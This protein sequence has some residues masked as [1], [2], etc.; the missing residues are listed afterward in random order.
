MRSLVQKDLSFTGFL[1]QELL[2][3]DTHQN[4][5]ELILLGYIV[6]VSMENP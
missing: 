5:M 1:K 4:N 3:C 6:A 2:I